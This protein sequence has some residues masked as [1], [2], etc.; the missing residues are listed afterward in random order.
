ME[1]LDLFSGM[2]GFSVAFE[3]H[4]FKTTQ[5]VEVDPYAQ[6]VLRNHWPGTPIHGDITTFSTSK[7][8]S[9]ITGGFPCQD[10]SVAGSGLGLEGSRS[11]LWSEFSRII[12]ESK[13]D[14]V[15][16]EN[17]SNLRN[18]G[19]E[20]V[21]QDLWKN[22]YDAEWYVLQA[23][24]FGATHRRERIIIVAYPSGTRRER[25]VSD[26]D[27]ETVG[28]RGLC[29]KET[30]LEIYGNPFSDGSCWPKPLIRRVDDGVPRR[31]DRLRLVGNSVYVPMIE[32]FAQRLKN[33][34]GG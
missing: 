29:S 24:Q 13:P 3:R 27:L 18:K 10:I 30:L 22:G 21:L 31:L 20:V 28:Q 7:K 1:L 2:G 16:I 4:G 15:L 6:K 33:E 12:G 8:Y 34:Y 11:G 14:F 25:L 17:S 26:C 5:F 32:F 23:Y 9:V 19:L